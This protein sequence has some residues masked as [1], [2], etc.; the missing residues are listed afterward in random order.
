[1]LDNVQQATLGLPLCWQT[2]EQSA[3]EQLSANIRQTNFNYTFVLNFI[4]SNFI[5]LAQT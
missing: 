1:V 5:R 2:Q 4:I 3:F